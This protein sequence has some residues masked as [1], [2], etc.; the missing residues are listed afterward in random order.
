MNPGIKQWMNGYILK[1]LNGRSFNYCFA[2]NSSTSFQTL[3]IF[4]EQIF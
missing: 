3:K 2:A 4:P 1:G